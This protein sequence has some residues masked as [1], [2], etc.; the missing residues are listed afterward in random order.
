V[1]LFAPLQAAGNLPYSYRFHERTR[2]VAVAAKRNRHEH[3]LHYKTIPAIFGERTTKRERER[4]TFSSRCQFGQHDPKRLISKTAST[5]EQ[6]H[7][8]YIIRIHFHTTLLASPHN[9]PSL[10]EIGTVKTTTTTT[11]THS[12]SH[13]LVLLQED[14]ISR[15]DQAKGHVGGKSSIRRGRRNR[16]TRNT[17]GWTVDILFGIYFR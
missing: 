16:S 17:A 8:R 2:S 3:T 10:K 5:T 6:H 1:I 14:A 15:V 12:H 9:P 7:F 11:T 13:P 4:V